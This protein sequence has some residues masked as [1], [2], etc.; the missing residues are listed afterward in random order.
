MDWTTPLRA[1]QA[2]FIQRLKSGHLLHCEIQGQHSE[3]T[4]ISED[5]LKVGGYCKKAHKAYA[6]IC[7]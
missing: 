5:V 2:D 6:E 3:L 1:Q 4:V 7:R